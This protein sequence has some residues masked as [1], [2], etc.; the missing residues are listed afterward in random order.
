M[1]VAVHCHSTKGILN[2][3][4]AGCKTIEHGSFLTDEAI[5]LM[6]EKDIMLISTR[7]IFK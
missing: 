7:S 1:I 6:L 4:H 5:K 3:I 2:A